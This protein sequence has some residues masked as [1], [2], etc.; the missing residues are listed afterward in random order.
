MAKSKKI[1]I[2]TPGHFYEGFNSRI[3]GEGRWLVHVAGVLSNQGHSVS[4]LSTDLIR[5]Y[6]DRGVTFSSIYNDPPP[7]CDIMFSMDAWNDVP[8]L[9]KTKWT[10]LLDRFRPQQRVQALFFPTT[11]EVYNYIPVIHP[12]KYQTVCQGL[13]YCLPVITHNKCLEP[14]FDRQGLHW[15][16]KRADEE[17]QYILGAIRAMH[18]LVV[19]KGA[20]AVFVDGRYIHQSAYR[21]YDADKEKQTKILFEQML[22]TKRTVSLGRWAPYDFVRE[23]MVNCKLLVG[24]H[25]PIAAPSMAEIAVSG[26][27]PVLFGNQAECPPYDQIEFPHIPL[28]A[29]DEEVKDFILKAWTDRDFFESTVLACQEAVQDHRQDRAAEII[30]QFVEGL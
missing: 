11:E 26:G 29:S 7:D 30:N 21:N 4:I 3:R 10:P 1:Y 9:H 23:W 5:T 20:Y 13:G 16:S 22:A 25:H 17:P 15:F 12:W 14:G 28:S 24:I 19:N 18:E 2:V 6:K 27:F 8:H